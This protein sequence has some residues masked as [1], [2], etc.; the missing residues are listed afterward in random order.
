MSV[1]TQKDFGLFVLGI[2]SILIAIL[3]YCGSK[4]IRAN[5]EKLYNIEYISEQR[6]PEENI[7]Q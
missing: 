1:E 2:G 6:Q 7:I 4:Q 5:Y 3:A